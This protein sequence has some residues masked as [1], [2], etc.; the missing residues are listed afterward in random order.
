MITRFGPDTALLLVDVQVGVDDLAHWGGP[1]GRRN[2][3]GAEDVALGLLEAFRALGRT[4]AWSLHDSREA[5]S[6]LRRGTPGFALKPGF[7]PGPDDVVVTKDVNSVFVG[8]PMELWLRRAGVR[9]LVV[10]GFFTNMCV[11]TSV[12]MAGNLGFDTYLVPEACATTNRVGPDGVDH[13]PEVAHAMSVANLHGEFCTALR[14]ADVHR[15]LDA[16]VHDLVRVQ[17]NE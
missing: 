1:T 16:D 4:V 9:R 17:G 6:P 13:D 2:N 7:R 5:T 8:T 3:P 11:D 12:R 14:L 15:L 10:T